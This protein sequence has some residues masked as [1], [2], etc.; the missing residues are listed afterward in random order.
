MRAHTN[1]VA[2]SLNAV[3]EPKASR[4]HALIVA[5]TVYPLLVSAVGISMSRRAHA[6]TTAIPSP[7][8]ELD[9]AAMTLFDAAEAREWAAA[10]Q[11]L[12]RTE[13]AAD[14]IAQLESAF[15][16][17]GGDLRHFFQARNDLVGDLIEAKTALS[18]KDQR[19]LISAADRIVARAG[20][21]SQ[22]FATRT[23]ALLPQVESLMYLARRMRR[24]L[25]WQDHIGLQAAHDDFKRLWLVLRAD[26]SS[27]PNDRV[28]AI[29]D[30]LVNLS[31]S[32][33]TTAVRQLY[34]VVQHLRVA[35]TE[36]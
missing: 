24:A 36:R 8:D 17:A 6:A 1:E 25:V 21:L 27:I 19:W 9:H 16:E 23:S 15:V 28:R 11:A 26:L 2:P 34:L 31:L 32:K 5:A 18:V 14:T 7:V 30:A 4:R 3:G 22:P 20:E 35:M 29:D 12:K 13:Q 33:S 10:S